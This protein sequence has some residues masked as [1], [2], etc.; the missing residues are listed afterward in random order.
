M[1]ILVCYSSPNGK[2]RKSSEL[3]SAAKEYVQKYFPKD[4]LE[5]Y[6]LNLE[7]QSLDKYLLKNEWKS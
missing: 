1:K 7:K 5:I 6:W 2:Y 3:T 4:L